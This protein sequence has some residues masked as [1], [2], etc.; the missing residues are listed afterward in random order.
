MAQRLFMDRPERAAVGFA[1]IGH[2]Q[3][4]VSPARAILRSLQWLPRCETV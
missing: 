3:R 1:T 2:R 4:V